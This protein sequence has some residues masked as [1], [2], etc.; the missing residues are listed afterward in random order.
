MG[1]LFSNNN[2]NNSPN[3][4]IDY[5]YDEDTPIVVCVPTSAYMNNDQKTV[6]TKN[7][8]LKLLDKLNRLELDDEEMDVHELCKNLP[9]LAA[10]LRESIQ[11]MQNCVKT[12]EKDKKKLKI[13]KKVSQVIDKLHSYIGYTYDKTIQV[14]LNKTVRSTLAEY[15]RRKALLADE[16]ADLLLDTLNEKSNGQKIRYSMMD[17]DFNDLLKSAVTHIALSLVMLNIVHMMPKFSSLQDTIHCD[18]IS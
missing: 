6:L 5:T 9:K 1:N 8:I 13:C 15:C 4:K 7:N 3:T 16:L 14:I 11:V 2:N 17:Y 12:C 10:D 18:L